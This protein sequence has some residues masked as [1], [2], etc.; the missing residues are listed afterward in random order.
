HDALEHAGRA[1]RVDDVVVVV[2]PAGHDGP[3]GRGG[4]QSGLVVVAGDEDEADVVRPGDHRLD[5]AEQRRLREHRHR[6]A[7]VEQVGQLA[8]D[9][10]VVDVDGDRPQLPGRQHRLDV[11]GAVLEV[12]GDVVARP[13]APRREV[14]GQA[15]GPLREL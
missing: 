6:V 10:A 4:G 8:G 1:A 7:V 14:V 2:A 9:V 11:L 15:V 5:G 3:L 12:E 13:D